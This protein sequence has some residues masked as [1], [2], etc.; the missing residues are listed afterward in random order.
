MTNSLSI[1]GG[2]MLNTKEFRSRMVHAAFNGE[3][4]DYDAVIR[5]V[6]K[7]SPSYFIL[8]LFTLMLG[9]IPPILLVILQGFSAV[10]NWNPIFFLLTVSVLFFTVAYF[11][12]KQETKLFHNRNKLLDYDYTL[13]SEEID[14][15]KWYRFNI[16]RD[17]YP[18]CIIEQML[19]SIDGHNYV[20][21]EFVNEINK[22]KSSKK[23]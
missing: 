20:N 18:V 10:V 1:G 14:F 9:L 6:Y 16:K 23:G 11:T 22:L 4:P 7:S 19:S 21:K 13:N 5:P 17:S 3:E 8:G 15:L 2:N 12:G